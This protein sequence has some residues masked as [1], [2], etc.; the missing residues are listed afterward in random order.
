MKRACRAFAFV[1]W[2]TAAIVFTVIV[3]VG[4]RVKRVFA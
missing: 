2:I 3:H 4:E 1:V